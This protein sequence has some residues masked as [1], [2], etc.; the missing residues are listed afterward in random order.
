MGLS[1]FCPKWEKK[2]K[3]ENEREVKNG[4][5]RLRGEG[6][7]ILRETVRRRGWVYF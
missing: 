4:R 2:K 6:V 5:E 1:P 3:S 7:Y